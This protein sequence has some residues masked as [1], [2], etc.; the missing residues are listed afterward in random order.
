MAYYAFI[1]HNNIVIEV[2]AGRNEDEIVDGV[3]DWEK[4]YEEFREGVICKRTSYNTVA[5]THKNG[6]TPFR[7][8]YAGYGYSWDASKGEDGAFVPPKPFGSWILNENS[9][10]WQPPI[11]KPSDNKL[12]YWLEDSQEWV[13]DSLYIV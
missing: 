3:T 13:A 8:N 6:K 12:Y 10:T 1:D 9:Y 7:Y 11:D 5:N 4:H 2:I